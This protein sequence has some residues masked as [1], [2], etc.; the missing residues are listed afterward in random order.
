MS[1]R[2][3]SPPSTQDIIHHEITEIIGKPLPHFLCCLVQ[4]PSSTSQTLNQQELCGTSL[5]QRGCITQGM[6]D[7]TEQR[8]TAILSCGSE[9]AVQHTWHCCGRGFVSGE[10]W[11]CEHVRIHHSPSLMSQSQEIKGLIK[12]A[13]ALMG[14]NWKIDMV[15]YTAD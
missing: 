8:L 6:W 9:A 14:G 4:Q 2:D 3:E 1:N 10:V 12:P 15:L 5:L 13:P 7:Q 11:H